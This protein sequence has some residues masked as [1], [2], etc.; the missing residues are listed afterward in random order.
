[1]R[2]YPAIHYTMGGLWVDYNL[3]SNAAGPARARR[4]ELLRP[5]REPPRRQRADAGPGRRLL[6]HPVH[7]RRLPREHVAR[8]VTDGSRR[9]RRSRVSGA[10]SGSTRLLAR[11]GQAHA[12]ATS[13]ARRR[14]ALGRRRDVADGR[15]PAASA[16]ERDPHAARRVLAERLGARR[17]DQHEPG[18]RL[19]RAASPTTSSSASCWRSTRCT[20]PSRAAG[21]SARRARRRRAKRCA[22]TT[23]F[24]YVAAW[25]FSGVGQPP[26]LHQ[27]PLVWENVNPSQRSYK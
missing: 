11:Q 7:D 9:L 6:R 12:S 19:R 21:T 14:R 23:H 16:V 2:I 20:A 5:R 10:R 22:T 27:E 13:T 8:A 17:E 1:M 15:G 24:S 3:M 4:G 26:T 25:E 18:A